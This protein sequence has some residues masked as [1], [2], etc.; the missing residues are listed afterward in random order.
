MSSQNTSTHVAPWPSGLPIG[1][2]IGVLMFYA[3][4]VVSCAW[5]Q[6]RDSPETQLLFS[7][8]MMLLAA[9][10]VFMGRRWSRVAFWAGVVIIIGVLAVLLTGS[11]NY[12]AE[13]TSVLDWRN[14]LAHGGASP[15]VAILGVVL[16][17]SSALDWHGRGT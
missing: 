7:G 4:A 12:W 17:V 10:S 8:A 3:S 11:A 5:I 13:M 9:G 16:S 2:S 6:F 15:F 1:A 14:I